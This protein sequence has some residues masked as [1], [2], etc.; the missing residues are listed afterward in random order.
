MFDLEQS[1][2]EWRKQMLAAG[3]KSPVPLEELEIHLR[4]DI[5][6]QIQSG[7]NEQHAFESAAR[8]IGQAKPV[9]MEFKKIDAENWNR[10]LAWLAWGTFVASF[11]LPVFANGG[12]GWQCAFLSAT[13]VSWPETRQGNWIDIHLSLLTLA[14]VLLI[15]SPFLLPRFSQSARFMKWMRCLYFAALM[16]VWSFLLLLLAHMDWKEL[17]FGCYV[18]SSSFFLLWLSTLKA[19]NRKARTVAN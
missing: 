11:F 17:K 1:I 19:R 18:W 3:I 15:A 5:E 7:A 2:A 12:W 14:N 6:R 13:A 10:P 9:K 8:Q 16:L 4:E